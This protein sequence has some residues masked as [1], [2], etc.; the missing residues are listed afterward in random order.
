MALNT[1]AEDHSDE[2]ETA[3]SCCGVCLQEQN[4]NLRG[5]PERF[6]QCYTCRRKGEK[7]L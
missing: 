6:L 5:K 3:I 2:E 4:R 1:T 7:T